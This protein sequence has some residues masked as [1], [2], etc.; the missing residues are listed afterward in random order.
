[1]QLSTIDGHKNGC[2][3]STNSPIK[4]KEKFVI[5]IKQSNA[6]FSSNGKYFKLN[7]TENNN[8]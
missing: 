2:F 8:Q 7:G 3:D 5:E 1:M 4:G 6:M